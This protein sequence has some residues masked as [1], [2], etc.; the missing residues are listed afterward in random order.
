MLIHIHHMSNNKMLSIY[1]IVTIKQNELN[2]YC[3]GLFA[4]T[5]HLGV[6]HR[7]P[8]KSQF[9]CHK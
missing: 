1:I 6:K 5:F 2:D 9:D 3:E 8:F 4:T 7:E